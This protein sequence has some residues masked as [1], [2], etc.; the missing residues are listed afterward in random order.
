MCRCS[1][2]T[3]LARFT[4]RISCIFSSRVRVLC[5]VLRR[6]SL[7]AAIQSGSLADDVI[8]Q[9]KKLDRDAQFYWDFVYVENAVGA[10]NSALSRQCLDKAEQLADQALALLG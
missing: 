6:R 10:H 7:A 3:H 9:I 4:R 2:R 5:S 8:E 1:I